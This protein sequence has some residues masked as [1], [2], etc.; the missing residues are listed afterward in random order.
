MSTT[1]VIGAGMTGIACARALHDA[2]RSV[3]VIDKGRG[4]GGRMATRRLETRAGNLSFDH[5]AQYISVHTPAFAALLGELPKAEVWEDGAAH[6]HYVGVPGMSSLPHALAAGLEVKNGVEVTSIQR[7][8]GAWQVS[9]VGDVIEATRVVLTVPAPQIAPLLGSDHPLSRIQ[10]IVEM[11]PS[12]TLMAAFPTAGPAPFVSQIFPDGP[13]SYIAQDNSKPG[14]HIT[15][16]AWVAQ[17]SILWSTEHLE[18]DKEKIAHLM[19]PLLCDMIGADPATVLHLEAHRWRYARVI[20]PLGQPFI[21][22]ITGTLHIGGDWC[23]GPRVESAWESGTA[24]AQ[25]IL[26]GSNV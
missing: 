8:N 12:L 3:R 25:D 24:I 15:A 18:Q 16:K 2:G 5:G 22:D 13:I 7:K 1:L 23:L 6:A 21:R 9:V 26:R 14:R 17:A 20:T 4:I 11:A 10:D 19:L